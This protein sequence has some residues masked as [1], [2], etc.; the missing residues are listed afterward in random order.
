MPSLRPPRLL[1]DANI[2]KPLVGDIARMLSQYNTYDFEVAD[3]L[4]VFDFQASLGLAEEGVWDEV[5]VPRAG[6]AGWTIIAGDRGKRGGIS[7]GKKLPLLCVEHGITHVLIASSIHDRKQ[8]SKLLSFLSVWHE[9]VE[10][11]RAEPGNRYKLE[12]AGDQT[13]NRGRARLTHRPIAPRLP[14]L[15]PFRPEGDSAEQETA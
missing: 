13:T 10:I 4:H 3:V 1:F 7:K 8:F 11:A 9:L 12:S 6:E 15:R 5:W 2:G 14:P